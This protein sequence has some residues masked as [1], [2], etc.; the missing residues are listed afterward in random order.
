MQQNWKMILDMVR[1]AVRGKATPSEQQF[2]QSYDE[3]FLKDHSDVID[4]DREGMEEQLRARIGLAISAGENVKVRPLWPR[5]AAAA[6]VLLVLSF[7]SY[8]FVFRETKVVEVAKVQELLPGS[9]GAIL[10]LADGKKVVLEN[11]SVGAIAGGIQKTNDS[12]LTYDGAEGIGFNTL[13]T[14][15]GRQ[16]SVVLPDGSRVWLNAA[17][18]LRYPTRFVGKERLVE[19]TGEGYFEVV[20]NAA[21]PFRVKTD[22]QLV[23]DIGTSFNVNAYSDEKDAVTTLVE[24]AASVNGKVLKPGFAGISPGAGVTIVSQ[25]DAENVVAWKN[26]QFSFRDAD[27]KTVMRQF[28]RWYDVEVGYDYVPTTSINGGA[29]R[30]VNASKALQILSYLN[31]HYRIEGKKI[32]ITK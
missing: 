22:R 16:Y 14:P 30:N 28:S 24:G 29:Y 21:M 26:G 3:L 13:E 19:L 1:K 15:K 6:S 9:N 11:E 23:E 25:V 12:L 4:A 27:I 8:Y 31:I 2:L 32:I 10:T 18:S 17:S 7:G 20:H 5:I